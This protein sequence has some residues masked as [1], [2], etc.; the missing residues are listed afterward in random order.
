VPD[1]P[2]IPHALLLARALR[3]L[4]RQISVGLPTLL[5]EA[6]TVDRIAETGVWLPVLR[7]ESELWLDVALVLDT[8]PSMCLWQRLGRDVHRLL[9]R[10]GEF[11]DV[12][13]WRLR[14]TS[15]Q[16]DLTDRHGVL[17]KPKELLVGD[18]RLVVIVSDCVAPAWHNGNMRELIATWSMK[19]PTVVFHVFPERLWSRTALARSV[20]VEF[21]GRQPGLPNDNLKPFAR[22]VWDRERLQESLRQS[23]V[24]LPVV[25]LEPDAFSSWAQLVAGDRR[26]RVLGIVWDAA[27]V[28]PAPTQPSAQST[29]TLKERI[30]SFLLTASPIARDL[31]GRLASAPV[32]TLPIVRIIKETMRPPASA[33]HMAEIF[34]SGL[35]KVSGSQV[36]TFDNAERIPYE[37]VDDEVRD[38]LRTG[39]LLGN[40]VD[41]FDQV[42]NYIA[43]G[44]GKSVHEFWAMLRTP[45]LGTSSAE[46][47]FL[48]AF[49]IVTDKILR[50]LGHEF[51][52]IANSLAPPAIEAAN[53]LEESDD[54]PLA[55]LEYE[56]AKLLNFPDLQP[57]DYESATITAIL[58]RFDFET[59]LHLSPFFMG[60]TITAVLDL[61]DF[62]TATLEQQKRSSR[63]QGG[64]KINRRAASASGYTEPLSTDSEAEIGLD[65]ILIPSGSF[66]MGAPQ[67]EPESQER[68]RPQ[69]EVALPPF[70]LGRH[71]VTQA[72]WRTVAGYPRI[73]LD[74]D[75]DPSRF[76]G[77]SR[78]VEHVSWDDAQEFCQRLSAKTGKSYCL[79]G[80]A[81]WE[82]ACRAGTTT[83]FHFGETITSELA[84]YS[85]TKTYNESP[86]GE[87]RRE[88]TDVDSFPA[89]DW[90]LHDM[91]G[92]A[93]EWCE[94]DWHES[95]DGA[96]SDGR[97]W[98][99][100]DPENELRLLR[101][102]SWYSV[103]GLCRSAY[104]LHYSRVDRYDH[105]GF[106]VCCVPPRLSS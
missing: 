56:V 11:R 35:L 25:S 12:R 42:T 14:H 95:Y 103:P 58:D 82:Y 5:N 85:G 47:E 33:V 89:N 91:H 20:T 31:A 73:D 79:P 24:Q 100:A 8:S 60:L 6:A 81:Q 9:S 40:A 34:M 101:G 97:A 99:E 36:P 61:F 84:N 55:D 102:G 13:I 41:V 77:D 2:A 87:Y 68:E 45:A 17:C 51:E 19:L 53:S 83:P 57:C 64:W 69:H 74:L 75:P 50:G 29:A 32:I 27:P 48:N 49:A 23:H 93:W 63:G 86:E 26:S 80:E 66:T 70:Y 52:A 30:D 18:R 1:A 94:D 98:V 88:T 90:G 22:S 72:Q 43:R 106:R 15:G 65:M 71:V 3:P 46:T 92:N 4:A 67:S 7:P 10:Y 44:L 104:R 39:S 38:R 105:V 16:V 78:P 96:P 21:Q 62:E 28:R 37:L 59:S 54:F 76:K